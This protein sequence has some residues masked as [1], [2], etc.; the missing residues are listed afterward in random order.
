MRIQANY[1]VI[2]IDKVNV[3]RDGG[4]GTGT[5][6]KQNCRRQLRVSKFTEKEIYYLLWQVD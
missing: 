3:F 4:I 1:V 6:S 2:R 5:R